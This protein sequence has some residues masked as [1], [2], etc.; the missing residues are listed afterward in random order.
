MCTLR[1]G[2]TTEYKTM[3]RAI[4]TLLRKFPEINQDIRPTDQNFKPLVSKIRKVCNLSTTI[5]G[6][7]RLYAVQ[8]NYMRTTNADAH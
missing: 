8:R 3:C 2:V 5:C 1:D 7:T 4:T 6:T